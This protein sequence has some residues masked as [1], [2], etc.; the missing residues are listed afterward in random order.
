MRLVDTPRLRLRAWRERDKDDLFAYASDPRVGPMAGWRPHDSA[1]TSRLIIR[2]VFIKMDDCW[3]V[4]LRATGQVIGSV[5]LHADYIR[6][7]LPSRLLGY[8][9]SPD[10]WGQGYATEAA[11]AA[12]AFGFGSLGL[13]IIGVNHFPGNDAS[14]RV[15]EKCGFRLE[16]TLRRAARGW[17]GRAEDLT[18]YSITRQ[19]HLDFISNGV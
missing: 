6:R 10:F 2:E 9:L 5:G 1:E 19:E 16:G 8:A 17:D 13:D 4:T 18:F 11:R 3:A 14:R 7:G 12:V 15:I